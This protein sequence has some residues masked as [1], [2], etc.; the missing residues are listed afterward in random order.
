VELSGSACCCTNTTGQV[1]ITNVSWNQNLNQMTFS[2]PTSPVAWYLQGTTNLIT[3]PWITPPNV[4]L[5]ICNAWN[6]VDIPIV[7]TN[8]M[9][10]R[11]VH[12][13]TP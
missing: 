3:G 5:N 12:T 11:L 9:F 10:F 13:N 6:I 8:N 2:W 7:P 1:S 4:Q